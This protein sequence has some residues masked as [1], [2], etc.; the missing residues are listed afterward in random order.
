MYFANHLVSEIRNR[1]Y[2]LARKSI[3]WDCVDLIYKTRQTRRRHM[4]TAPGDT[5]DWSGQQRWFL[6]LTQASRQLRDEFRPLHQAHYHLAIDLPDVVRY[7][8]IFIHKVL[9]HPAEAIGNMSVAIT[10][11][12]TYRLDPLIRI[13]SNSPNIEIHTDSDIVCD[14]DFKALV[15]PR[16]NNLVWWSYFNERVDRVEMILE[17][18]DIK[19]ICVHVKPRF[20]EVWMLG[21]LPEHRERPVWVT[22]KAHWQQ[23][24]GLGFL[25]H[26]LEVHVQRN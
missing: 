10:G 15:Y 5:S 25:Q 11:D 21:Y 18:E 9:S 2:L 20:A 13:C 16:T 19:T 3:P 4:Y 7:I 26:R 24:I 17:K 8:Y 12:R 6:G 22:A 23:E 1:I 14:E